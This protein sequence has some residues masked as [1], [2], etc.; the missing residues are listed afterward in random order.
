M[1]FNIL[2]KIAGSGSTAPRNKFAY[3]AHINDIAKFPEAD[4]K[5]VAL[6]DDI[7]MKDK[8]GMAQ[9]Y[10][11]PS[12]QEYTYEI[13]GDSD[14]KGFKIKF[15]GTH[16]GTELEALEFSKNY[17]EEGFV[18]LIPSCDVGL[19]VLG[20]PDAP[21]IFTSTH[22]S[23][24]D[25]QKFIFTF[26]QEIGSENVYQ[27]YTGLVTLNQN[28]DVDMGDFLETLKE[29]MKI[30]GSNLSDAQKQNLRTILG[31]EN[32]NLGNSDLSLNENRGFNLGSYFL[33]FFSNM[34]AKIGINKNNPTQ[35][36]DV[37][38]NIKADSFIINDSGDS[39]IEG[40]I[41][42]IGDEIKFKTAGG[43]ET[44]MLK[45]DYVSDSH[46]LISPDT[47][48]PAGGWQIG[49]YEP[50][51]SS[52]DPGTNY[53]NQN[54][55]KSVEGYFTKF[56]FNGTGWES[57]KKKMPQALLNIRKWEDLTSSDFPLPENYQVIYQAGHWMV[58][59][60]KNAGSTDTPNETS[61]IWVQIG[62]KDEE[63]NK[64][65]KRFI[66]GDVITPKTYTKANAVSGIL[67]ADGTIAV[68][69]NNKIIEFDLTG[70]DKIET[71][72]R[73]F[74]TD[75]PS[76]YKMMLGYRANG[77]VV[78]LLE[79]KANGSAD[80]ENHV[81]NVS[82][83]VMGRLCYTTY[84]NP[85]DSENYVRVTGTKVIAAE[86]SV[87]DTIEKNTADIKT[88]L[89]FFL[90]EDSYIG[91]NV[92]PISSAQP[93]A[94]KND[95]TV[96]Y[97]PNQAITLYTILNYP[98]SGKKKLEYNA[99]R[100]RQNDSIVANTY[101]SIIGKKTDGSLQVILLASIITASEKQITMEFDVQQFSSVSICYHTLSVNPTFRLYDDKIIL[102]SK[103]SVK[104][105]IDSVTIMN[106]SS[107]DLYAKGLRENKT[108]EENTLI[109]NN[110]FAEAKALRKHLV[111][112][113]GIYS[114]A[115]VQMKAGV[116]V[117]GQ[118][119]KTVLRNTTASPIL[120]LTEAESQTY[121]EVNQL[122]L[123]A[124][125]CNQGVEIGHFILSGAGVATKGLV[126]NNL[127]SSLFERIYMTGFT[128]VALD[129]KGVLA[130]SFND[131]QT[132][133]SKNG[134]R[135]TISDNG[136]YWANHVNFTNCKLSFIKEIGINW[137]KGSSISF[138]GCDFSAVG[139]AG[140]AATGAIKLRDMSI[141]AQH[142]NSFGND[143]TIRNSYSELLY[144][145]FFIDIANSR[146][147]SKLDT[148]IVHYAN[149][150]GN[151]TN[152]IINSKANFLI[153]SSNLN[154][155]NVLSDAG[156]TKVINSTIG[157]HTEING[158]TYTVLG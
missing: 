21:L 33:N 5:G 157:S 142:L 56:Y 119:N 99:V 102:V 29:Y 128:D 13:V 134:I 70:A 103:D 114:V 72:S 148:V 40:S 150:Y 127:A 110:A 96:V 4:Y 138:M 15:L 26:E 109:M 74:T 141:E 51:V 59:S 80:Y 135:A 156:V 57:V 77:T 137:S 152:G 73:P 90:K 10:I 34:G 101:P 136:K 79:G 19:K 118:D 143:I 6:T 2:K 12:A 121:I 14:S 151:L 149:N 112:P 17:L 89:D 123:Q 83:L 52:A 140:N 111:I 55:L 64:V 125:F 62:G 146:G 23:D 30:D 28:I 41:K 1:K 75:N 133:Y 27:L 42:R 53:P 3:L 60:G 22:K 7:V 48:V 104:S 47:T 18:I 124:E 113:E 68:N 78:T 95:N 131:C 36:L 24:K 38:G 66:E 46:G 97:N 82:D 154:N 32:K 85:D 100:P 129:M 153:D 44:I 67:K 84:W 106:R 144:G 37:V 108:T 54:N 20:T 31:I 98:V 88:A 92:V 117:L 76:G 63:V 87:F 126:L 132:I 122:P 158:G 58:D 65:L 25:A 94:I 49:W 16:P 11:T 107:I 145:G 61:G 71:R 39:E 91:L 115:N 105:Y 35:A 116:N 130:S 93:G 69:Q 9:I 45:G 147:R 50:K 139:T 120:V 86:N 155:I 81:I 8:T 43:W